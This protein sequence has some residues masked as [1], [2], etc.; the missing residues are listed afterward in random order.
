MG[1]YEDLVKSEIEFSSITSND[2]EYNV[3]GKKV[4]EIVNIDVTYVLFRGLSG[5]GV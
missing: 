5:I 4:S 1:S 3:E 2:K